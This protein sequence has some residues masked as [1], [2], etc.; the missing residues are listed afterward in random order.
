MIKHI[1]VGVTGRGTAPAK[2][3]CVLDLAERHGARVSLL[4][5]VDTER[6]RNV[7]AVPLG[8]GH[9]ARQMAEARIREARTAGE[10]VIDPFLDAARGRGVRAEVIRAEG[11]PVEAFTTWSRFHDLSVLGLKHWFDEQGVPNPEAALGRLISAGVR[12]LVAVPSRWK[13]VERVVVAFNGSIE[14]AKAMRQFAVYG[15]W[16][17]VSVEVT[18]VG[19]AKTGEPTDSMLDRAVDYLTDYGFTATTKRLTRGGS[20]PVAGQLIAHA[21]ESGADLLVMGSSFRRL[22]AFQRMGSNA[23]GTIRH[24]SVPLFLS[25]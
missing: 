1:L 3:D 13:P 18:C 19:E 5:V 10:S 11:D 7:G 22:L 23:I 8:A 9:Y 2:A 4:F 14:S 6:L 24:A 12:P 17:G 21:E 15:G 25:H 20:G 16:P